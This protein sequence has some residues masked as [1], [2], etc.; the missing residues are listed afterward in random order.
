MDFDG[1]H[2]IQTSTNTSPYV[3]QYK[4][5]I[6]DYYLDH[7]TP[8]IIIEHSWIAGTQT[9]TLIHGWIRLVVPK[10]M[11]YLRNTEQLEKYSCSWRAEQKKQRNRTWVAYI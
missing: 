4:R 10:V 3:A 8:Y 11:G 5:Q 6:T 1:P 7:T 2:E 9:T